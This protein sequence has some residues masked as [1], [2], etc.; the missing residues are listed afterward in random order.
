MKGGGKK[1]KK[2]KKEVKKVRIS[3]VPRLDWGRL[4][5]GEEKMKQEEVGWC[6]SGEETR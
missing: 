4:G 1:R 3:P 2:K 5:F 6:G